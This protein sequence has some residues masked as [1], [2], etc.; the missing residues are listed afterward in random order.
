MSN[1][2]LEVTTREPQGKREKGAYLGVDI[3]T[4]PA[5]ISARQQG[6]SGQEFV[7]QQVQQALD[8]NIDQL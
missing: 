3:F 8:L 2:T 6:L 5:A 1:T 4:L 7:E